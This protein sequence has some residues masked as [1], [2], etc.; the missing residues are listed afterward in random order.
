MNRRGTQEGFS[1]T[2][3]VVVV[4][5]LGVLLSIAIPYFKDTVAQSRRADATGVLSETAQ[6][7]ERVF[8]ESARYDRT[9]A[10]VA[11]VVPVPLQTVPRSVSAAAA[12]YNVSFL[13]GPTDAAYTLQAVPVN[14]MAGDACGTLTIDSTGKKG[15]T[16]G[17]KTV[18][19]CWR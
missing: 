12:Y 5:V 18:A 3:L 11:V 15:V 17:S 16:G 4:G 10:G 6:Y 14:G 7:L 2:E 1:F 9:A 19:Q 8:T 13:S